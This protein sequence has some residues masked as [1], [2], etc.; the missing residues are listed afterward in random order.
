MLN[1]GWDAIILNKLTFET[2]LFYERRTDILVQRNVSVPR[3]TGMTLPDENFGIV[4]NRGLEMMLAYRENKKDFK[5][6][7]SGN[8]A[9]SR[10]KIVEADEPQA[11]VPWQ[12]RTGHPMDAL[13]L[14]KKIGIFKD[15]DQVNSMPHVGGARPGDII[16]EDYDKDGEITTDDRQLFMLTP[17]PEITFG[18]SLDVS[19]KNWELR[20]LIQGQGRA[21]REIY[22]E[23]GN[24]ANIVGTGGNYLQWNA[25]GRWT[26]EHTDAI[27]PRAFERTEEYWRNDYRTDYNFTNNSFARLKNLQ[28]SYT[29]SK[30]LINKVK[31]KDCKIFVAGQNLFLLY[32]A[33]KIM[34][35]ETVSLVS[36]PVTRVFSV[37]MQLSF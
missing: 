22:P 8:F 12:T 13:L 24:D 4:E 27:A 30:N 32:S 35:P 20:G 7:I 19:Y 17:T 1:V 10:N 36:Y 14:Y 18:L 11:P 9:F 28:L 5:Y 31:L 29:F 6:G 37:G 21:L 25:D 16:I 2:D 33:N 23:G 34:D 15:V 3:F 26:P